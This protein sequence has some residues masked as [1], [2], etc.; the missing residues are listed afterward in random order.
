MGGTVY[1]DATQRAILAGAYGCDWSLFVNVSLYF[2]NYMYPNVVPAVLTLEY[3][4]S[5]MPT[6]VTLVVWQQW[7]QFALTGGAPLDLKL[8]EDELPESVYGLEVDYPIG[9]AEFAA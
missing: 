5:H 3:S 7:T 4:T 9:Y 2:T 8:L 6:V 1:N